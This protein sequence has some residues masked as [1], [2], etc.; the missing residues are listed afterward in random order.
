[1]LSATIIAVRIMT[2]VRLFLD[3]LTPVSHGTSEQHQQLLVCR[4]DATRLGSNCRSGTG[5][6]L[7]AWNR[8]RKRELEGSTGV[9]VAGFDNVSLGSGGGTSVYGELSP[10]T[11]AP[12]AQRTP[13]A[14]APELGGRHDTASRRRPRGAPAEE[15][16]RSRPWRVADEG[17]SKRDASPGQPPAVGSCRFGPS[18]GQPVMGRTLSG[19]GW[20]RRPGFASP[21]TP[22][23]L[24]QM[25]L[26]PATPASDSDALGRRRP[27]E[28]CVGTLVGL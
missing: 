18:P 7:T 25:S 9:R 28:G 5:E 13:A 4:T 1:M 27:E 26:A 12:S 21:P 16:R 2:A 3:T 15:P 24:S 6:V 19:R 14:G 20:T 23:R 17:I 22:D 11:P 10:I 8:P